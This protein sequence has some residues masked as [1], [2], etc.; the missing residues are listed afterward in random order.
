MGALASRRALRLLAPRLLA[1]FALPSSALAHRLDE[2]LQA[3]LVSI[4]PADIR[5]SMN[6]TPGIEVADEV[7]AQIDWNRDDAISAGEEAT[8]AELLRR[9]LVLRLDDVAVELQVIVVAIPL[10]GELRTGEGIILCSSSG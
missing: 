2:Y 10:P 4:E 1:L 6:L 9:D 5:L 8:Y 3:A 7:L